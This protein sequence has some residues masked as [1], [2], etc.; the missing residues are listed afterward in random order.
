VLEVVRVAV[1]EPGAAW[2][3]AGA[4]AA[5]GATLGYGMRTVQRVSGRA[6]AAW[7]RVVFAASVIPPGFGLWIL[8]WEGL[9][10]IALRA[11]GLSVA[12][13][14]LHAGLGVWV[15]RTWLKVL[16][17][18]RLAQIMLLNPNDD[19]GPS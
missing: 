6:S 16:E 17:I 3:A 4:L 19:G 9:R 13:A 5:G 12:A 18:E 15:L 11:T 2:L 10:V 8:G 7:M 14:I 1:G